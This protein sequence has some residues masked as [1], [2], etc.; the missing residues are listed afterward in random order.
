MKRRLLG[1]A[2]LAA[3]GLPARALA[4]AACVPATDRNRVAFLISTILLSLLPLV[5]I[6]GG[7]WWI[8][9][10]ARGRLAGEFAER[11]P[12]A[13]VAA[14]APAAGERSGS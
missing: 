13:G 14:Q 7:L 11:E 10:H 9:R 1:F 2:A 12:A 4:C 8:A 5:M 3:C 6:G